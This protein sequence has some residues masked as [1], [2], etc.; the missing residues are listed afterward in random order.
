MAACGACWHAAKRAPVAVTTAALAIWTVVR[1]TLIL[2]APADLL[3]SFLS[4]GGIAIL[5]GKVAVFVLLAR[6]V[7]AARRLRAL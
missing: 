1:L 4:A 6:A 2:V 7:P 5:I 3:L